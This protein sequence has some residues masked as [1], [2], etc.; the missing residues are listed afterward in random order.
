LLFESGSLIIED[1]PIMILDEAT[2]ALDATIRS[3]ARILA[4]DQGGRVEARRLEDLVETVGQ[5]ARLARAQFMA[6]AVAAAH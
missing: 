1:Q 2:S 4:F 3:P 6:A 5:F